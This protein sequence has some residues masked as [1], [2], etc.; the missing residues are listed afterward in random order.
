MSNLQ[1]N[2]KSAQTTSR[3]HNKQ[4]LQQVGISDKSTS[5]QH[6][7]LLS[8]QVFQAP[9]ADNW[10][11][12][13]CR[14]GVG[15]VIACLLSSSTSTSLIVVLMLLLFIWFSL[16]VPVFFCTRVFFCTPCVCDPASTQ[17]QRRV[18]CLAFNRFGS[19]SSFCWTALPNEEKKT[20]AASAVGA[21]PARTAPEKT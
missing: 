12:L 1:R 14:R 21:S 5:R 20:V 8:S 9:F 13:T 4:T 2:K 3:R 19:F 15:D 18:L 10:F 7:R 17:W 16:F 6:N 11:G